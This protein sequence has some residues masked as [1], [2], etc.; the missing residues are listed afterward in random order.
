MRSKGIHALSRWLL[1][2]LVLVLV[3]QRVFAQPKY[4]T[5]PI[6]I[7]NSFSP[8]GA[9]DLNVRALETVAERFL[10]K[11]VVQ[12][13]K[14]GGGGITGTTEVANSTPDGYKLLIVSSGELTAG[15]KT[16]YSLDSFAFIAQ[17]SVKPYGLV[18]RA[19]SQ[20]KNLEEFRRQAAQQPGK[21][22]IGTTPTGGTFL[23]AQYFIR[24]GG[25]SLTAVPY[26]GSGPYIAAVLGGHLDSA[27]APVPAAE[28]HLSAGTLRM[29]AV[30]GPTR[31]KNYPNAPT[32][33]ALGVDSPFVQWIGVVA[34]RK[35]PKDRFDFLRNTFER[36]TKDPAY[37]KA[38]ENLGIDVAYLPGEEFEKLVRDED[39]K[40]KALV[41][42]LGLGPK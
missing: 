14:P 37:I 26:P 10:G 29:L 39:V 30:T 6:E 5:K 16:A 33:N 20:W 28:S 1:L 24:K 17:V 35:T 18:V 42:E 31:M 13:F 12:V 9:N 8:G 25:I 23:T 11:P 2:I 21:L 4:P 38:A 34:P 19:S 27:W 32:L 41:K 40:F 15:P 3:D 22:T 36:I 7:V